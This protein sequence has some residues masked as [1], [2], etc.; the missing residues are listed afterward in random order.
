[1]STKLFVGNLSFQMAET[2]L[3]DLFA[4]HG[5]VTSAEIIM[6]KTTGRSRGFG[7]VTMASSEAASSAISALHGKNVGGRNLTVNEARPRESAPRSG[8]GSG[9][10]R[11]RR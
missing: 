3:N 4:E 1:M 5:E 2:E 8:G 6:D 9:G 11:P 10:Y 7:F